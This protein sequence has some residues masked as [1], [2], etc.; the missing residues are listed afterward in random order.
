MGS[1]IFVIYDIVCEAFQR[2]LTQSIVATCDG[3]LEGKEIDELI[4]KGLHTHLKNCYTVGSSF[5]IQ[6][7]RAGE[8]NKDGGVD[9]K[10]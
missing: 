10:A 8:T 3:I 2:K 5:F 7:I 9:Q 1:F 4:N 6:P